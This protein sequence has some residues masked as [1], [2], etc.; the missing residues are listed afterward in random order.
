MAMLICTAGGCSPLW[1]SRL[2]HFICSQ[3]EACSAPQLP[4]GRLICGS[5]AFCIP[6]ESKIKLRFHSFHLS[7]SL[8]EQH[9]GSRQPRRCSVWGSSSLLC[10]HPFGTGLSSSVS[11]PQF[12]QACR[13][14]LQRPRDQ[15]CSALPSVAFSLS[16]EGVSLHIPQ[17][18]MS[19]EALDALCRSSSS[20]SPD[21]MLCV[22]SL[23]TEEASGCC[24]WERLCFPAYG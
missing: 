14:P 12:P 5:A 1:L 8:A 22:I 23:R 24:R 15:P 2:L 9:E 16:W 18:K 13:S 11:V 3:W 20:C 19:S 4:Q 6:S 17:G 21:L 10:S 7:G